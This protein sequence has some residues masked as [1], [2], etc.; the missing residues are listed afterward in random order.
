MVLFLQISHFQPWEG[1]PLR[2]YAVKKGML[3]PNSTGLKNSQDTLTVSQIKNLPISKDKIMWYH[4]VFAYYVYLGKIFFPLIKQL[5]KTN[6]LS[7][8]ISIFLKSII[9]IRW[10]FIR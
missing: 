9:I 3:D 1:T 10:K 5:K 6:P 7:I 4:D 8:I 2:D